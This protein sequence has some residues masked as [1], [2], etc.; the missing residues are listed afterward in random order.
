MQGDTAASRS[1]YQK[2][3]DFWK[4]ADSGMPAK[5]QAARELAALH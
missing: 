4:D 5:D 3:L 1:E 2:L